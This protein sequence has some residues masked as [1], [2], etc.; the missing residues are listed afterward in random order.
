M[1]TI[2]F[3]RDWVIDMHDATNDFTLGGAYRNK[4]NSK[5]YKLN[6]M[7]RFKRLNKYYTNV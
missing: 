7:F 5:I 2:K 3:P 1:T 4:Y 6:V